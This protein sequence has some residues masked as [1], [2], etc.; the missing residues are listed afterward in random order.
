MNKHLLLSAVF[1]AALSTSSHAATIKVTPTCSITAAVARANAL[2]GLVDLQCVRLND[3]PG[4]EDALDTI[5][6]DAAVPDLVPVA[7]T[8]ELTSAMTIDGAGRIILESTA[9]Q[10]LFAVKADVTLTGLTLRGTTFPSG[11]VR[12]LSGRLVVTRSTFSSN[13]ASF[14]GAIH[15]DDGGTLEATD[16]S[17][18][19]NEARGRTLPLP[20]ACAMAPIVLGSVGNFLAI[21]GSTLTNTGPSIVDGDIGVSP[22]TAITGFPPGIINGSLHAAD[23]IAAAAQGDLTTA[24]NEAAGR[25]SCSVSKIGDIG[26]QT[27]AP[28]LY[29]STS[30][31]SVDAADLTLDAMGDGNAV[32][33]FQ[34]ASTFTMLSGRKIILVNG[35]KS[36]NI[37]WQ[38]GSS[39]TIGT[40]A[41]FHGTI[42]ALASI[43]VTTNASVNGRLLARNGAVTLDSNA[44]V[45]PV[46]S[47]GGIEA[48]ST[49]GSGDRLDGHAEGGAIECFGSCTFNRC[50][51]SD[52]HAIGIGADGVALGGAVNSDTADFTV[53]NTTFVGN[54]ALAG[55]S[56]V[57]DPTP[58]A[59]R[60]G[61]IAAFAGTFDVAFATL[62]NNSALRDLLDLQA[63]TAG[64]ALSL[65]P[66]LINY[67]LHA[68]LVTGNSAGSGGDCD[69]IGNLTTGNS[70]FDTTSDRN[71]CAATASSNV[72]A[73]T[74]LGALADN[75]GATQTMRFGPA[76]AALNHIAAVDCGDAAAVDQRGY[77]RP[78]GGLCDIGALELENIRLTITGPT[79]HAIP[80]GAVAPQTVT[81]AW[82]ISAPTP[83]ADLSFAFTVPTGVTATVFDSLGMTMPAC[84]LN[85]SVITCL[86]GDLAAGTYRGEIDM[87]FAANRTAAIP[88]SGVIL[89]GFA[90]AAPA[91][92]NA[93]G[94][95]TLLTC[96]PT[97]AVDTTCDGLDN[98]CNGATDEGFV[99]AAN[100][101]GVGAC[102]A[103]GL[104][105]CVAGIPGSSCVA[106][107]PAADDATCNGVD[108]DCN[109]QTDED[110][111]AQPT[112]CGVGA[113]AATGL[114]TCV[115]GIPGSSCVAGTPAADDATCNGVDNDCNGQTDEDVVAQPTTCG[116]GVCARTGLT[117]CISGVAGNSC[118]AGLPAATDATCNGLD[119]DCNGA[120]DDGFVPI[121]RVCGDS[122]AGGSAVTTCVAGQRV[123]SACVPVADGAV[124][125]DTGACTLAA[126]CLAG[127]CTVTRSRTCDDGNACTA[128]V[129]DD[130][131]GCASTPLGNGVTCNDGNPCTTA[132]ACRAGACGGTALT[133]AAPALC[134][135]AGVC[136]VATG[137]CDYPFVAGCD[138]GCEPGQD[139][140]AP[141]LVCPLAKAAECTDGGNVVVVG[142]PTARDE[143]GPVTVTSNA[144]VAYP[145]GE[146]VVTFTGLDAAGNNAT[147]TTMVTVTDN[148][149][150]ILTCPADV[151]VAG[152]P[153]TCGA[154]VT[155]AQPTANDGCDGD[156]VTVVGPPLDVSF[157]AGTTVNTY[158]AVD[159][160]GN[161]A[162][163]TTRVTVTGLT[164]NTVECAAT[165]SLVADSDVCGSSE[166]VSAE[167]VVTCGATTTLESDNDLFPIGDTA[168]VFSSN[169]DQSATCTTVVTVVDNTLPVATCGERA[170]RDD[171]S[172]AYVPTA[173]DA[174]GATATASAAR[175]E[176]NGATLTDRCELATTSGSL[177]V[178]DAAIASQVSVD[179]VWTVTARDPSGNSASIE[180]RTTLEPTNIGF[181]ETGGG[182]CASGGEGALVGALAGL[183]LVVVVR[184]RRRFV[185]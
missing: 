54:T 5:V 128:D 55:V 67:R 73:V 110:V 125:I 168:I 155:L 115:A 15:V 26:G 99:Q 28:G 85:N 80:T 111:V 154:L 71:D 151:T 81:L 161:Q 27:L 95:V 177:E 74:T 131:T 144:L 82:T 33:I 94:V 76:S 20:L 132:D 185:A 77:P 24:Y 184:N 136:N 9:K 97:A 88:W 90:D 165:V 89:F 146:T 180:C 65:R 87:V 79:T 7:N 148:D 58:T 57:A 153:L 112:T 75:G 14:G 105:T 178:F 182:G 142:T 60:G 45:R 10:R 158:L 116:V 108:N 159:A 35:A 8:I 109:G 93:N 170:E 102:A 157:P 42:L 21:A 135:E 164:G 16:T 43:T 174:C 150:P 31:L 149:A 103:T 138:P 91:D 83:V 53:R 179:V 129:C 61:A 137:I 62:A 6:F 36:G 69:L 124:C 121:S 38:V 48:G 11:G 29:K 172:I 37:Y 100:S 47:E 123:E 86:L 152:N 156:G 64:G 1:I 72:V 13:S 122:C 98:N 23:P 173:S 19:G 66:A 50:L 163:C 162:G 84:T 107:T 101:C 147:C 160:A 25:T 117:T 68:A 22:G 78:A 143:C 176:R 127:A 34:A 59:A 119:N 140:T 183:G 46:A 120:T 92:D 44:V 56:A 169:D 145:L 96:T 4:F 133:C 70:L 130:V 167:D 104:T 134:E 12:V 32:W 118:V 171:G 114:S 166:V 52:N 30:T 39:A 106:G 63:T 126:A 18:I 17:F 113:C 181:M 40:G 41:A 51:F 175:C 141:V 139:V 49:E 2:D 3:T